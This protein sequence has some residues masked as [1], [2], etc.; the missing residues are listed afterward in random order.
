MRRA[1][2]LPG[3][4]TG[5][6]LRHC[7]EPHL[8]LPHPPRRTSPPLFCPLNWTRGA[9]P[10]HVTSVPPGGVGQESCL[11]LCLH[12]SPAGAAACAPFCPH[13][14]AALL[15]YDHVFMRVLPLLN[16]VQLE[17]V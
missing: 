14:R 17:P 7:P 15:Q 4:P 12:P 8:A 13:R 10:G 2:V 3:P 9:G 1:C 6:A 11:E 5:L 16:S